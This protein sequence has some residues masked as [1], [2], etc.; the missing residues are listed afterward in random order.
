MGKNVGLAL[1]TLMDMYGRG[2]DI[3]HASGS[4]DGQILAVLGYSF[5]LLETEKL[6]LKLGGDVRPFIR[7]TGAVDG[8]DLSAYAS[9]IAGGTSEAFMG[10]P[11]YAGASAELNA[12]LLLEA[13]TSF[14][15]GVTVRYLAPTQLYSSTTV[16][17]LLES[18]GLAG[19]ASLSYTVLPDVGVGLE[20]HPLALFGKQSS[21]DITVLSEVQDLVRVFD[22]SLSIYSAFSAGLMLSFFNNS[23]R[24]YGGYSGAS[25]S[26][27]CGFTAWFISVDMS[28]LADSGSAGK[29]GLALSAALRF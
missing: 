5:S 4:L 6:T 15:A 1:V 13:G 29:Q 18:F 14:K 17:A 25:F 3:D 10:I 23:L 8:E 11:V 2:T 7:F 12:G 19:G 24:C 16:G 9:L 28:V 27:G 22:G 21:T 20:L 26:F